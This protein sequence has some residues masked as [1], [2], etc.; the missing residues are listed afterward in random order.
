MFTLCFV[1]TTTE[2]VAT[3]TRL[4]FFSSKFKFKKKKNSFPVDLSYEHLMVFKAIIGI[5]LAGKPRTE[6]Q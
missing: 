6:Q 5:Y 4:F 2:S 1:V 3:R